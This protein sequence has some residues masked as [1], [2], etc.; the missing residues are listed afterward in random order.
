MGAFAGKLQRQ[1]RSR[2]YIQG[3]M[4]REVCC[5]ALAQLESA[6]G[7]GKEA[8]YVDQLADQLDGGVCTA[9]KVKNRQ[10]GR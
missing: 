6:L 10:L 7:I 9:G 3:L 2:D 1:F 8:A 4:D 5:R